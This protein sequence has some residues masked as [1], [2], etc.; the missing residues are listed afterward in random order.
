MADSKI[1][2]TYL[3]P[4]DYAHIAEQAKRAGLPLST[5]IRKVCQGHQILDKV[6]SEAVLALLRTRGD[7]GRLGGLLKHSLSGTDPL[8]INPDEIRNL[9]KTIEVTQQ[10]MADE[11]NKV[12]QSLIQG[13]QA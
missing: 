11:F 9:L 3:P 12:S 13:M 2:K 4:D 8:P 1:V 7:L 10:A 6:D 5:Y